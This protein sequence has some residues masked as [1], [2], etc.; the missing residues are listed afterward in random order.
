VATLIN[1][2]FNGVGG[3]KPV[4]ATDACS[5]PVVATN[6]VSIP[7]T[8]TTGIQYTQGNC[9]NQG[10][11][12]APWVFTDNCFNTA[13]YNQIVNYEDT[14]PPVITYSNVLGTVSTG[15]QFYEVVCKESVVDATPSGGFPSFSAT[16]NCD[17]NI[18]PSPAPVLTT[19]P[20]AWTY[21]D[22]PGEWIYTL[23]ATAVDSCN[24]AAQFF[25]KWLARVNVDLS[26]DIVSVTPSA[27]VVRGQTITYVVQAYN[28]NAQGLCTATNVN[29]LF[30]VFPAQVVGALPAGCVNLQ[31]GV[32]T[33]VIASQTPGTFTQ[34]S[35]NVALLATYPENFY[36]VLFRVA[37][38]EVNDVNHNN[39]AV[40][41]RLQVL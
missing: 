5:G 15:D 16:D 36:E 37:S 14:I 38:V 11:A 35:I 22:I 27:S 41:Y 34:F 9:P 12:S 4:A 31:A 3:L 21:N 32:I 19:P 39:D 29:L 20:G 23:T 2:E 17:T 28:S 8:P 18:N 33:C 6:P 26:V 30:D 10:T 25:T 7:I 13:T 1:N 24:N 40:A